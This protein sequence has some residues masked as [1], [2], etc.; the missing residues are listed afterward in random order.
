[1]PTRSRRALR[2]QPASDGEPNWAALERILGVRFKERA[3]LRQ[4]FVHRSFLNEQPDTALE[5]YERL[6]FLG[7]AFLGWVVADELYARYPAFAEGDMTRARASLVRGATLADVATQIGVGPY[8]HLGSGEEST[9]GRARRSTLAAAV[10]AALGAVLL[11]RGERAARALVLR[12]LG[13]RLESLDSAGAPRDAKSALQELVQSLGRPLP[14]YDVLGDEGPSH[15]RRYRVSVSVGG[16]PLAEGVG[17]RKAEAE[18]A[19]AALAR[20]TIEGKE[21]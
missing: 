12:W 15:D 19:A 6:E 1:M 9:G 7:D 5:S 13:D 10:E 8:L 3:L 11:D 18:Q 20:E 2:T 14:V 4:A 17:R 16:E 21:A